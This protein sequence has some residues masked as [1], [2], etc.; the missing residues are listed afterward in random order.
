[1]NLIIFSV[2]VDSFL[3]SSRA[4][5]DHLF[6]PFYFYSRRNHARNTRMGTTKSIERSTLDRRAV[7]K[8]FRSF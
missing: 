3:N 4:W 7:F 1:M 5:F 8:T 2:T 6:S